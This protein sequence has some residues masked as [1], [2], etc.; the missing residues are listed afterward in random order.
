MEESLSTDW[1]L[2]GSR[3]FG[4][5]NVMPRWQCENCS[6][7]AAETQPTWVDMSHFVGIKSC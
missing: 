7:C 4:W 3:R 6:W 1:S 2:V 5:Q